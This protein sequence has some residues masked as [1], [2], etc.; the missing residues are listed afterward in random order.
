MDNKTCSGERTMKK[1]A[2]LAA[3]AA[4]V[5]APAIASAQGK[6]IVETAVGA[7]QFNTLV[8]AVQAADLVA[9]LSGTGPFTVFAPN[10]AAFAKVPQATLAGL[11]ADK[12]ALT[13]VLTYHVIAGKVMAADAIKLNGQ[14]VKT[15]NGQ[16]LTITVRDGKVYVDG[17]QVIAA[18]VGASNGVIHV[19]DSVVLPKS[20]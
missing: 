2:K 3:V 18:D 4:V 5:V 7:G 13:A 20:N 6:N 10:D 14:K 15:V 17:A 1:L 8:T 11:L 16:E 12:N 9:T 19:I